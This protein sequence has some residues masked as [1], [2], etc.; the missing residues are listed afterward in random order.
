MSDSVSETSTNEY[1]D[2]RERLEQRLQNDSFRLLWTFKREAD[3]VFSAAELK[4]LEAFALDLTARGSPHPKDLADALE[5]SAPVVSILLRSLEQRGFL[6]RQLDCEDHRR[7]RIS[8]TQSGEAQL[9][10]L[11]ASWREFHS[12]KL[13]RLSEDDLRALDRIHRT[14]LETS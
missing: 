5:T 6:T 9:E 1:V 2:P 13:E 12:K 8:L 11:K 10:A 7:T 14:L 4:P 3:A